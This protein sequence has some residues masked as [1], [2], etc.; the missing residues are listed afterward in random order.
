MAS[1]QEHA[2][3]E[4]LSP[5]LKEHQP[6]STLGFFVNGTKIELHNPDPEHTLLDFIRS[7]PNLKG[8]KLG[9]GEGG[10]Y[11]LSESNIGRETF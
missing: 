8:T 2:A 10:W 4:K 6:S 5:F 3:Y 11:A 1:I 7:Q 9:C